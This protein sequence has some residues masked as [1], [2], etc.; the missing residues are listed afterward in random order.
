M[1][2]TSRR[3]TRSRASPTI[4]RTKGGG[5]IRHAGPARRLEPPA[6]PRRGGGRAS[7]SRKRRRSDG[8]GDL[9]RA[10]SDDPHVPSR[11][12]SLRRPSRRLRQDVTVKRYIWDD[13]DYCR[14][15]A[16]HRPSRSPGCRLSRRQ[17]GSVVG[18]DLHG[19][20]ADQFLA[21]PGARLGERTCLC[22]AIAAPYF[23]RRG[24]RSGSRD[25]QPGMANGPSRGRLENEG[26]LPDRP[27]RRRQRD[28]ALAL[29]TACD[30]AGWHAHP[31]RPRAQR[32]RRVSRTAGVGLA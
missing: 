6:A 13:L 10:G 28:R 18:R 20:A 32:L 4:S 23:R 22:A 3:S 17:P 8:G 12:E 16:S 25:H 11:G 21:G 5:R 19:P 9:P 24:R 30:M 2:P 14:R 31:R 1:R 7:A 15:S 26:A 29:G 27:S